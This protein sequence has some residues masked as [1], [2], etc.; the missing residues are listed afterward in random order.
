MGRLICFFL[1]IIVV[2][3][4][5]F[6]SSTSMWYQN[7]DLFKNVNIIQVVTPL[8]QIFLTLSIA[9]YINI[10]IF[11]NN[12]S[13]E[14]IIA[15]IDS[16]QKEFEELR[17]LTIIYV[18]RDE[19]KKGD[20]EAKKIIWIIKQ[21]QLKIKYNEEI[22]KEFE[23]LTFY[24]TNNLK[25]DVRELKKLIT[26]DPFMQNGKKYTTKKKIDINEKFSGIEATLNLVK[27]K[28]YK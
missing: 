2:Y 4:T 6:L 22:F 3:V 20:K 23:D 5:V 13:K 7:N 24:N 9:Y 18:D 17:T 25:K 11:K 19:L 12:K 8:I 26:D 21:L 27:L 15:L 14:L 28:L 1:S 10:K 16:F